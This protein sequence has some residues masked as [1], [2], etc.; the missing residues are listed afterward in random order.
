MD[1]CV[2]WR[3]GWAEIGMIGSALPL[4]KIIRRLKGSFGK[5]AQRWVAGAA[6]LSCAGAILL[7]RLADMG[8]SVAEVCVPVFQN[9]A[10]TVAV[11]ARGPRNERAVQE[12]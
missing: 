11:E 1:V 8:V 5:G 3:F 2:R 4:L 10:S 9:P 12:G 6:T 7:F